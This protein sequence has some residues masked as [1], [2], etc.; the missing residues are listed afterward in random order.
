MRIRLRLSLSSFYSCSFRFHFHLYMPR[1]LRR[2]LFSADFDWCG[3]SRG[4]ILFP[5]LKPR[6][7]WGSRFAMGQTRLDQ[8]L[9]AFG[10]CGLSALSRLQFL[11]PTSVSRLA[12][13]NGLYASCTREIRTAGVGDAPLPCHAR[14]TGAEHAHAYR[15]RRPTHRIQAS[16]VPFSFLFLFI[17]HPHASPIERRSS[18]S[19]GGACMCTAN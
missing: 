15:R 8:V 12:I 5:C 11:V 9:F 2:A 1:L 3:T 7:R 13:V 6:S 19:D 14:Y 4:H 17:L 16:R 10:G 18:M